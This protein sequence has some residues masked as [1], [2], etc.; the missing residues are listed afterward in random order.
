MTAIIGLFRK[1][2]NSD[3]GAEFPDFPWRVSAGRTLDEARRMATEALAFHIAAMQS[4]GQDI[5]PPSSLETVMADRHNKAAVAVLVGVR[6]SRRVLRINVTP[7]EHLVRSIDRVA[8]D[9]SGFL[10]AAARPAR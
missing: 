3:F 7:P 10:A 8:A 6:E 9:R 4:D 1:A 2:T 5:P